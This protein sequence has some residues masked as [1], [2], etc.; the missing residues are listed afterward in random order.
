MGKLSKGRWLAIVLTVALVLT[1][2]PA[3]AGAN[4][5]NDVRNTID[6]TGQ[7]TDSIN[8]EEYEQ[9]TMHWVLNQARNVEN[10]ELVLY[11]KDGNE[12]DRDEDPRMTGPVYHFYTE[13]YDLDDLEATVYF[14]GELAEN[15][16]GRI[17]SQF[18]L[19]GYCPPDI[20][21]YPESGTTTVA[22]E[23]LP[24]DDSDWD[25]NDWVATIGTEGTFRSVAGDRYLTSIEFD[26]TPKARG[27]ADNHSFHIVIPADTFSIDGEYTLDIFDGDGDEVSSVTDDFDA[28]TENDF[29]IWESTLDALPN[30]SNTG[31]GQDPVDPSQTAKVSIVFDGDGCDDFDFGDYPE[32]DIGVHGDGLFFE[33]ILIN[34]TKN[35]EVPFN[36]IRM[37]V[38]PDDWRWPKE[39]I[40]IWNAYDAVGEDTG[41]PTFVDGWWDLGFNEDL[42]Y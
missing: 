42:V 25:Y 14:D 3:V 20:V 37:L 16:R 35:M 26:I 41:Q 1:L 30:M 10:P 39:Q 12:L 4:G 18:V 9:G 23:D 24:K 2:V 32:T 21:I 33:P 34:K 27:A 7:G 31:D 11:D 29:T 8:C 19:S 22:Y 38:V 28:T 40:R 5:D 13:Y 6:W 15:R 36:D 17:T